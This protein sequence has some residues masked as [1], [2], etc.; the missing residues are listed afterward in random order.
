MILGTVTSNLILLRIEKIKGAIRMDQHKA[1]IY[2]ASFLLSET[3]APARDLNDRSNE[4]VLKEV[5]H[6]L[7]ALKN[8]EMFEQP[9]HIALDEHYTQK[10]FGSDS[11]LKVKSYI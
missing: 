6:F 11:K 10:P 9:E 7:S 2:E 1:V 3:L 4:H 5:K 8:T